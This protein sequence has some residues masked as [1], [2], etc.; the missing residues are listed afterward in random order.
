MNRTE[1]ECPFLRWS[2]GA[3]LAVWLLFSWAPLPPPPLLG[4]PIDVH[5]A[6]R[7]SQHPAHDSRRPSAI[8]LQLLA[9][10]RHAHRP[11]AILST[12]CMSS[13]TGDDRE[14]YEPEPY[15]VPV[16]LFYAAASWV[17]GRAFGWKC[18]GLHVAVADGVV[19]MGPPAPLREG[20]DARRPPQPR[21]DRLALPV[22][23]AQWEEARRVS[24]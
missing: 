8:A 22:D 24:G 16:S 12:I 15:Y 19:H 13:I 14:R 10:W 5:D 11:H 23:H 17:G 20:S 4:D 18:G 7:A 9:L 1:K 21:R 2:L 3:T 6:R